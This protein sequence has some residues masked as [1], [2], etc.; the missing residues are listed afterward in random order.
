MKTI[1]IVIM[2][3]LTTSCYSYY[4]INYR[5]KPEPYTPLAKT[6]ISNIVNLAHD[7]GFRRHNFIY[8]DNAISFTKEAGCSGENYKH[9]DGFKAR[10]SLYINFDKSIITF[11]DMTHH[12]ETPYIRSFRKSLEKMLQEEYGD[13]YKKWRGLDLFI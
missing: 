7:Y 12:S 10:I 3:L 13:E 8:D 11:S 6:T 1:Y 9:L 4:T 5:I 2:L